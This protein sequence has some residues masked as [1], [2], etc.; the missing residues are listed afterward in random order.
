MVER[1]AKAFLGHVDQRAGARRVVKRAGERAD[2][3][4]H[5]ER[6]LRRGGIGA[7]FRTVDLE[8]QPLRALAISEQLG[9]GQ[10]THGLHPEWATDKVLRMRATKCVAPTR[11]RIGPGTFGGRCLL[12]RERASEAIGGELLEAEAGPI[13]IDEPVARIMAQSESVEFASTRPRKDPWR[14]P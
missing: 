11:I 6:C 2:V 4:S 1:S 10:R 13:P 7:Q 5:R 9:L 12:A 8:P 3:V 14:Y